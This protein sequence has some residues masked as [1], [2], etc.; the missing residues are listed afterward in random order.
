LIL[1]PN[2]VNYHIEHH[3]LPSVPNYRLPALHRLLR[4]RGFYA[5]CEDSVLPGYLAVL[6][7][8]V[9]E[10]APARA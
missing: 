7:R 3:F 5:G 8:A 10:L 4:E 1:C 2:R 6:R 9:P